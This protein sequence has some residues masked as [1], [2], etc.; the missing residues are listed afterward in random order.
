VAKAT[1]AAAPDKAEKRIVDERMRGKV[2][3]EGNLYYKTA[4]LRLYERHLTVYVFSLSH[5]AKD[6]IH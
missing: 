2:K 4:P 5:G 6:T 1:E 3:G